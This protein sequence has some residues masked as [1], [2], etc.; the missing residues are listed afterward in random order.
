MKGKV[1]TSLILLIVAGILNILGLIPFVGI[2]FG[3]LGLICDVLAIVF[4]II[5]LAS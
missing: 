4:L 3:I 5:A 1:L 2:F